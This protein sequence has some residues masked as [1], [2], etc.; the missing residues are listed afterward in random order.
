MH[1]GTQS[2]LLVIGDSIPLGAAE[3]RDPEVVS[4]V[5]CSCVDLLRES[6]PNVT[7]SLEA[8]VRRTTDDV[9]RL[10][11]QAMVE[12]QPDAVLVMVGGSDADISWRRFII[13]DGRAISNLVP[14][15]R[16]VQNLHQ[17]VRMI[18]DAGAVPILTDV[19][20]HSLAI[21]AP[22]LSSLSGIDV[23]DMV[24]RRGGQVESD[25]RLEGYRKA[26][27]A[28]ACETGA[29]LAR[30]G[31]ALEELPPGKVL[32]IDGVHPNVHAHGI[33]ARILMPAVARACGQLVPR[34]RRQRH[35]V[36]PR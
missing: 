21:R 15:A 24:Q 16:Y 32:G 26:T 12:T 33:I 29:D 8:G 23:V 1:I 35:L 5:E 3:V 30:Y 7:I 36:Q 27:E 2:R 20:N 19:P 31:Q 11:P 34:E 6:F 22:Y 25:R 9:V 13:T 17:I 28:V 4:W 10:L 18:R 14:L